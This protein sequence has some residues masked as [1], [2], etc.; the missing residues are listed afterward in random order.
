MT[1]YLDTSA[2]VKLVIDEVESAPLHDWIAATDV[3]LVTSD[4]SR[5]ELVRAVRRH[6]PSCAV[7]ARRILDSLSLLTI[8]TSTYDTAA[9]LVPPELRTLDAVHLACALELGDDLD[10]LVTYDIRLADAAMHVGIEVI[11]PGVG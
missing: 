11:T 3:P 2:L 5:T 8:P 7:D 4:L 10:G 9:F 1:F 6:A